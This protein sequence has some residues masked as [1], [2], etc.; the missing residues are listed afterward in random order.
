MM[1]LPGDCS[2]N[3]QNTVLFLKPCFMFKQKIINLSSVLTI[4]LLLASCSRNAIYIVRHAEKATANA[5]MSSDVPLSADGEQRAQNLKKLLLDKNVQ[6]IFSTPYIRTKS[7]AKPLSDAT[8]VAVQLYSPKDTTDLFIAR[9]KAIQ[10][11]NVL[12]V[13]HSN[14]VDG[15][16]NKLMGQQLLT[17]LPETE[18]DNLFIV[19]RKGK[20]YSFEKRKY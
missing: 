5:N 10:K 15:L 17:D 20:K 11:R 19:K 14:T 3:L 1:F 8:Q 12:I 9:V 2:L 4:A 13:G 18:Y 6:A 16:V 7:T